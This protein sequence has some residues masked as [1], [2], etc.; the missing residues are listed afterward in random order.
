MILTEKNNTI[1]KKKYQQRC[2]LH[3]IKV[4][5]RQKLLDFGNYFEKCTRIFL[6]EQPLG[7]IGFHPEEMDIVAQS[8]GPRRDCENRY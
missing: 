8:Y 6:S 7:L 1:T 2:Q 5:S 3:E 4:L